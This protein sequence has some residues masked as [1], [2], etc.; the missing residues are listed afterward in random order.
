MTTLVKEKS[1]LKPFPEPQEL[2]VAPKPSKYH[3]IFEEQRAKGRWGYTPE[4]RQAAVVDKVNTLKDKLKSRIISSYMLVD[5]FQTDD[6]QFQ[7]TFQSCFAHFGRS[8]IH[9]FYRAAGEDMVVHEAAHS[10]VKSFGGFSDVCFTYEEELY[11]I[12]ETCGDGACALHALLGEPIDGEC[13][14][15]GE[16]DVREVFARKLE[17]NINHRRIR[18]HLRDILKGHL[19]AMED[20]SSKL[21]FEG[22]TGSTFKTGYRQA[23][24]QFNQTLLMGN[25]GPSHLLAF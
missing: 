5:G 6:E 11:A 8:K 4:Q 1:P 20:G 24:A 2:Q 7:Q 3:Q 17:D 21:L 19:T 13:R 15:S 9:P 12:K 10:L 22:P 18:H 25:K 16:E 23:E 14:Y